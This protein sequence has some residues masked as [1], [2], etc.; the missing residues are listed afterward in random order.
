MRPDQA[1][2]RVIEELIKPYTPVILDKAVNM[3]LDYTDRD[4]DIERFAVF[5]KQ[6]RGDPTVA[7]KRFIYSYMENVLGPSL[8]GYVSGEDLSLRVS[9]EAFARFIINSNVDLNLHPIISSYLEMNG[10][11]LDFLERLKYD[12]LEGA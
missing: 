5:I 12:K 6:Y 7:V 2:A 8:P 1:L 10:I 4:V 3:L 9:P 11:S